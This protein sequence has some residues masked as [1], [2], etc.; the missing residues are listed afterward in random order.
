MSKQPTL[1]TFFSKSPKPTKPKQETSSPGTLKLK[2]LDVKV[3]DVVWTKLDGYPWWPGL[4]CDN[5]TDKTFKRKGQIHVQFF[6][7]PPTRGWVRE[8]FVKP[9]C[10]PGENGIPVY[11]DPAWVKAVKE[12]DGALK[13]SKEDRNMLLV[14]MVPSDDENNDEAMDTDDED[15]SDKSKENVD[16]NIGKSSSHKNKKDSGKEPSKKR[17]RIILHSDSESEDE[18]KPGK[19]AEESEDS[20]SSGEDEGKITEPETE[21]EVDSPVKNS[22][23]RK[24]PSTP[25]TRK[26]SSSFMESPSSMKSPVL[27][28]VSEN[29]KSKLSL[30]AAKDTPTKSN[31]GG[32]TW[33]F[34]K[35]T[36]LFPENIMDR[37]RRR[38][39]DPNYNPKTVHV[40]ESFLN[41]QTPGMR[42]WWELKS[43]HYDTVLFFKMGKFYELFHMDAT[44]GV[45]ELGLLMMRGEQ[46]H[47]GFPEIAYGR[48][49]STLI[50]KGYKVA[51]IEQT[52]TPEMMEK[53]IKTLSRPT[54][55]DRVV[56]RE[57]CQISTKG[58][59][60]YSVLDGESSESST[61]YLL[62]LSERPT[63]GAGDGCELGVAFIDTS[64]GTFHLGQFTDDRHVSRLRTLMAH[65]T[66]AQILVER[67]RLSQKTKRVVSA[68]VPSNLCDNLIPEKEFWTSSKTLSFLAEGTY[69]KGEDSSLQWPE[70]LKNLLDE[71]D[72]LGLTAHPD[73]ELAVSALGALIW[74]LMDCRLEEQLLTRKLFVRYNPVDVAASE[75]KA[76]KAS[77]PSFISNRH[78]MVLD[79]VTLRNLEIFENTSGGVDGTLYQKLDRCSTPFGKRLL[80][81]WLCAPLCN[82]SSIESRLDAIED[83]NNHPDVVEEVTQLLKSLPDL[84][85]LLAKIHTQGLNR[86]SSHPDSR[87]IF[88]EE[89]KYNKKKVVDFLAAL[90][91]FKTCMEI[92]KSF[93]GVANLLQS[94]L[95]QKCLND[96]GSG[97]DFP[98]LKEVL[99]F[100]DTAFDHEEAKKEGTIFPCHGVDTEYD[101]A[102][103]QIKTTKNRLADY[104]KE[105]CRY[106]G[107]KVVYW[108]NDK[109]RFQLEVP[110]HAC[111]RASDEYELISQK[112]GFKRYWTE[113]TK[114]FLAD[115]ISG[116]EHRDIA[117]RDIAR[118]IF[119]QFDQHREKWEAAL[120]CI[121]VLDVLISLARYST[122]TSTVRPQLVLPGDDVKPFIEIRDGL[123][124]CVVTTYSGDEFIP[125]DLVVNSSSEDAHSHLVLVTGPNM[126][127]KSTLMRQTALICLL[128]QLG[129]FVPAS[130]CQLSPIDRIFTRL[131]AS[132]RIMMGESTFFVELAETSSIIQHATQ[133]SLV[134]VDELGRGTATYD[135]TAIASAVV[136]ALVKL[137]CRTLFSTHY[138]SLVDDF[139]NM[140]NVSLGHMACMVEG[141]NEEDPSQETIT[142]L[143]KFTKGACPKSYGFN[144]ARLADL[145]DG[146]IRKGS[147]KARELENFTIKKRLFCKIF[148]SKREVSK[149]RDALKTLVDVH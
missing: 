11:K 58:T 21:S 33:P 77:L 16:A 2:G 122:E 134:L 119:N 101:N 140:K 59:R 96:T 91:G 3:L 9:Y 47:V 86:S 35:Y 136:Q 85:R 89:I 144:A 39:T 127:G 109:K 66:P 8:T 80:R 67:G 149:V 105:Q 102:F 129:S 116:E 17:R 30:F 25:A 108:G 48:Y 34:M 107:A 138:H 19:E 36:W 94:K 53:R 10:T 118:R 46:A 104:L 68:S 69:F 90:N 110:D 26:S 128:A 64:I 29:T 95:L 93:K 117:L 97:G 137:K 131:G 132:D 146:V 43:H 78:H 23:K 13:L 50:E 38:P 114:S 123:H 57:I 126:G 87:A 71:N 82:P 79:G 112:K 37:E 49:S 31:D 133:H 81:K 111:K 22:N 120:Q 51:R 70:E 98:A 61:S 15:D 103:E 52:E 113:E 24:K 14:D 83:L 12:A 56:R 139:G 6:D 99:K 55:F 42:Q 84:E 72:T 45:Q 63:R 20:G 135:G 28:K 41:S 143:Y 5:P 141:E 148:E 7:D 1:F 62:A 73:Y 18:Y 130:S 76:N 65:Y 92:Q 4:I 100:F 121:A 147:Q 44:L 54:K 125:N 60:V 74:Y 88:F 145:P 115:M 40:P 32:E 124:P 142:F 75:E 27:P 106:F